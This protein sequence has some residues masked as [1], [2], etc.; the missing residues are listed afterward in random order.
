MLNLLYR[1]WTWCTMYNR[2]KV[3]LNSKQLN[4][5]SISV[6]VSLIFYRNN[7]HCRFMHWERSAEQ[8]RTCISLWDV[9]LCSRYCCS[10]ASSLKN[11][12]NLGIL[13]E[14]AISQSDKD[15]SMK[16]DINLHLDLQL[17][18]QIFLH[19][20]LLYFKFCNLKV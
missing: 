15:P 12:N 11:I 19:Q 4:W 5:L 20:N 1:T 16:A 6:I 2:F 18:V 8:W 9:L 7:F 17:K 10:V 13:K 3:I 14:L